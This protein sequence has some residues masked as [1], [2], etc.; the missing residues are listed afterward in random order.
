VVVTLSAG[1]LPGLAEALAKDGITV[2]ECPLLRFEPPADWGPLDRALAELSRYRALALTSPR[3]AEAVASRCRDLGVH[4]DGDRPVAWATGP[5][6]AAP[7]GDVFGAVRVPGAAATRGVGAGL[8]LAEAM[9]AAN[10]ESPVLY[11]GGDIRRDELTRRLTEAGIMVAEVVCYRS[12]LAPDTEARAAAA[13]A[14]VLVVGSPRVAELL[15][16]V[17]PAGHRPR[18]LVLG[19]TTRTASRR[20]GWP[21]DAEAGHATTVDVAKAL[22]ALLRRAS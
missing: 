7:L 3:A 14:D 11:P 4:R 15:A 2:L 19:P 20:L 16:S 1:A 10:I 6:T 12:V 5:A 8:A 17:C 22:G 13:R 21:P 9:L 18:L